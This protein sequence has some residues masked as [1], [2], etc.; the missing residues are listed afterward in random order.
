EIVQPVHHRARLDE[1]YVSVVDADPAA[2]EARTAVE[3]AEPELVVP[4]TLDHPFRRALYGRA[5]VDEYF[6]GLAGRSGQP[7]QPGE[8]G[9][10]A[11]VQHGFRH[12]RRSTI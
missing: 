4:H 8:S 12:R 9:G 7:H 3:R 10:L 11:V 1:R 6:P 2:E 5:V